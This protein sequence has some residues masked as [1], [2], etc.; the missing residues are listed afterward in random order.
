MRQTYCYP[1]STKECQVKNKS[2]LSKEKPYFKMIIVMGE[3]DYFKDVQ[4]SPEL[5][6]KGFSSTEQ[7]TKLARTR[8]E[9]VG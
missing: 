9:K 8:C 5:G 1:H 6:K 4:T 7:K 3:G 2:R